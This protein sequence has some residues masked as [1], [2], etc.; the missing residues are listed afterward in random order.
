MILF[1]PYSN[2]KDFLFRFT[3][4]KIGKLHIRLHRIKDIDKSGFYHNHPFRY[5]SIILR[6]GYTEE[7]INGKPRSYSAGDIVCHSEDDYHKITVVA[8]NTLT[9]FFA[10]GN[11]DWNALNLNKQQ[12]PNGVWVRT[13]EGK[14]KW[15]KRENDIWFIAHT[16]HTKAKNE[17]RHSIHQCPTTNDGKT[18]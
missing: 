2:I 8:P 6:G 4:L 9:L 13:I 18:A 12:F 3:I 15:A 11:Y 14:T 7:I 16:D 1:K 17:T 10:W 5:I